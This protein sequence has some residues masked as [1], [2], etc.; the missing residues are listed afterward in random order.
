MIP[1]LVKTVCIYTYMI[2]ICIRKKRAQKIHTKCKQINS[3]YPCLGNFCLFIGDFCVFYVCYSKRGCFII[4]GKY[5]IFKGYLSLFMTVAKCFFLFVCFQKLLVMSL[6]HKPKPGLLRLPWPYPIPAHPP[7]HAL[8]R[9][10][11][12]LYS[13]STTNSSL[14]SFLGSLG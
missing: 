12:P 4:R 9:H 2:S 1:P 10:R 5:T 14:K 3:S 7:H 11:A 8:C 13:F 6:A